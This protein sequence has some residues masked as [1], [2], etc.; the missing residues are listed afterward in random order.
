M[1]GIRRARSSDD[2][3]SLMATTLGLPKALIQSA[4]GY[5]TTIRGDDPGGPEA[6]QFGS[7]L[8][9]ERKCVA[10][11]GFHRLIVSQAV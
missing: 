9:L 8:F 4:T 10:N 11:V 6:V 3:C 1:D 5:P 7:K 2:R